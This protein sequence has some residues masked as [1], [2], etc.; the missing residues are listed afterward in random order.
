MVQ[1]PVS[2]YTKKKRVHAHVA[3][4]K[5]LKIPKNITRKKRVATSLKIGKEST[6][7]Y[8]VNCCNYS[9]KC[10]IIVHLTTKYVY[11]CIGSYL[12]IGSFRI[13]LT[14]STFLMFFFCIDMSI[15]NMITENNTF[16]CKV[17][18]SNQ[19]EG[20]RVFFF[21]CTIYTKMVRYVPLAMKCGNLG[22]TVWQ[23]KNC[24]RNVIL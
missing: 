11:I 19:N 16:D 21:I 12:F 1:F 13:F 9:L 5:I 7:K 2:V 24:P 17:P 3:N 20:I 10:I 22:W 14:T 15:C 4:Y 23:Q 8:I 18:K 6:T